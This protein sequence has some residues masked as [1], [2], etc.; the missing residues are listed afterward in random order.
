LPHC[1]MCMRFHRLPERPH[2][3]TVQCRTQYHSSGSQ[4]R[5]IRNLLIV[6]STGS[7]TGCCTVGT[8]ADVGLA[9][10][11]TP[12]EA[13]IAGSTYCTVVRSGLTHLAAQVGIAGPP[14]CCIIRPARS[15][16][17]C[18]TIST[19][20]P[21]GLTHMAAGPITVPTLA[22]PWHETACRLSG[23]PRQSGGDGS[24]GRGWHSTAAVSFSIG[25]E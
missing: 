1:S 17:S 4:Y 15:S 3:C 9:C 20:A 23:S 16:R 21:V 19:S 22:C 14:H 11:S 25:D 13:S 6:R 18:S 5:M 7:S 12:V 2:M 24:S 8:C 10:T